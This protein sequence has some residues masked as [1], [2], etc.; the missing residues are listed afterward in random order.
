MKT[1]CRTFFFCIL[2][3]VKKKKE[4][5]VFPSPLE[6]SWTWFVIRFTVRI[7]IASVFFLFNTCFPTRTHIYTF[8]LSKSSSDIL[9]ICTISIPNLFFQVF[10]WPFSSS[11]S[12]FLPFLLPFCFFEESSLNIYSFRKF[13][14]CHY[15]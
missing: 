13:P 15:C 10:S 5:I 1:K 11:A 4:I 7:N 12:V 3:R 9:D 2:K 14:I 8:Y 6:V